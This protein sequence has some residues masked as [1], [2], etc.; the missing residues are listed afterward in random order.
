MIT[1]SCEALIALIAFV[2]TATFKIAY[3]LGKNAKK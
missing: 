2:A 1:I 3:E